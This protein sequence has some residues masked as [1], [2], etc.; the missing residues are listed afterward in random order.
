MLLTKHRPLAF[1]H[2]QNKPVFGPMLIP[3]RCF[4]CGNVLSDKWELFVHLQ[5]LLESDGVD[6]DVDLSTLPDGCTQKSAAGVCLDMLQVHQQCCRLH[7]ICN[8][9]LTMRL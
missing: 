6:K 2:Y 3:V 1:A 5:R 7:F 9:D 8:A 4:T